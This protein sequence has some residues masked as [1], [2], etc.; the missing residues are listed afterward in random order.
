[1]DLLQATSPTTQPALKGGPVRLAYRIFRVSV[2]TGTSHF[3]IQALCGRM[4]ADW[5]SAG[6]QTSRG[7]FVCNLQKHHPKKHC[8]LPTKQITCPKNTPNRQPCRERQPQ[9][10]LLE[11]AGKA[12][13]AAN[14]R[15]LELDVNTDAS[16]ESA[17]VP[18]LKVASRLWSFLFDV[19]F[20]TQHESVSCQ[21]MYIMNMKYEWYDMRFRRYS[22]SVVA[23]FFL[24]MCFAFLD[25]LSP[26]LVDVAADILSVILDTLPE[27]W[28]KSQGSFGV[29]SKEGF[30]HLWT[31]FFR[32]PKTV[33]IFV[34]V[35]RCFFRV[36]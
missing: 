31:I 14:L 33:S 30:E 6:A 8:S 23:F 19:F 21:V 12:S 26:V 5:F 7:S 1:M 32:W 27:S 18:A 20:F 17:L 10:Q 25:T 15:P 35:T 24:T 13:V 29:A 4:L 36:R 11:A 3:P 9:E 22:V 16:V 28:T 34:G 2:T